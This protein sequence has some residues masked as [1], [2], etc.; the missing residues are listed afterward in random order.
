MRDKGKGILRR[1]VLLL[2]LFV[3]WTIMIQIIDVQSIGPEEFKVGFA[4]LNRWFH[5]ATGVQM[6]LYT[7]TD[8]LGLIP[9]FAGIA[10]GILGLIQLI[11]RKSLL[12]VDLDIILLGIYYLLVIMLY[13]L[14]EMFPVNYRPILIEGRLEASYPSSTTLLVV[15]VMPT[16]IFEICRRNKNVNVKSIIRV[17]TNV[18][19]LFMVLGRLLSGV[20]W[21][22]DI[23]GALLLGTGLF[24]V[25]RAVV[26]LSCKE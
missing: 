3:I 18:F 10:F 16:V 1:G 5:R 15:S 20:H 23:C 26:L 9:I 14:F 8:W 17:S 12:K 25:Y 13:L 24:C 4:T 6:M 7:I 22:T 11:R 2:L 21:F 19:C